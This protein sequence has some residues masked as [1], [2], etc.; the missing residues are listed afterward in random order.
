[1]LSGAKKCYAQVTALE[2]AS[3]I[4]YALLTPGVISH[5]T[6]L[7]ISKLQYLLGTTDQVY[8]AWAK[9]N[10]IPIVEEEIGQNTKLYW[11]GRKQSKRVILYLHA[12]LQYTLLP[13]ATFPV[14]LKQAALALQHLLDMDFDPEN[15]QLGGDSAGGNLILQLISHIL[16]PLDGIPVV[17][18]SA[19]LRGA[20]LISPWVLLEEFYKYPSTKNEHDVFKGRRASSE[21]HTP[22]IQALKAP[23]T[24][25]QGIHGI[26]DRLLITTGDIE[27][28]RDMIIEFKPRIEAHHPDVRFIMQE[29]G[30]HDGPFFDFVG[31]C[32]DFSKTTHAILEWY[33]L[34]Y[35]Q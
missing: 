21:K 25:F 4:G 30:V 33:A 19:P 23:D 10:G 29:N 34:G 26:V 9:N 11:L 3:A 1:M 35:D 15:I 32:P 17:K 16:H 6:E 2:K 20:C 12:I 27:L 18:I 22:Y 28:L 5:I 13:D 24:W 31:T 14:Q 8:R 7:E